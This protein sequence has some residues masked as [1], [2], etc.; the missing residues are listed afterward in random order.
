MLHQAKQHN[1]QVPYEYEGVS[2]MGNISHLDA[3]RWADV[4]VTHLDFTHFTVLLG[5]DIGKPV[6]HIVHNHHEYSSI[7]GARYGVN[8]VYNSQ[9][10]ADKLNYNWPSVVIPPS[11]DVDKYNVCGNPEQ[12]EYITMI[13]LNTNKGGRILQKIATIFPDRKFLAVKGSYD[14]QITDQPENVRVIDN[15]PDILSV[16]AQ[17]RL[18]LMPS[19]YESWGMTATEAMCSGIPVICTPTP[20]LKENC[21]YAGN[22][23][24]ARKEEFDEVGNSKDDTD[25]YDI[26]S[27]IA[28]IKKF[29]DSD[30]YLQRSTAAKKRSGEHEPLKRAKDYEDFLYSTQGVVL[31]KYV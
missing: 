22:Y 29:D 20:G 26:S 16:Y 17:T 11:V 15:T 13:N 12:N 3:Y 27:L 14:K 23:I 19:Q 5:N 18:L 21:S 2:V 24:D 25:E 28:M 1:I 4:L 6:V 8:V 31:K 30:Y 9:W 10:I 7:T